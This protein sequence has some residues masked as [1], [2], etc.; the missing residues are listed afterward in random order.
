MFPSRLRGTLATIVA[1]TAG[2]VSAL[3]AVPGPAAAAGATPLPTHVFAPYFETWSTDSIAT[4][5]QQSGARY[6]TLAFLET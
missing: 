5:A 6:F 4:V 1:A 2:A 3:I